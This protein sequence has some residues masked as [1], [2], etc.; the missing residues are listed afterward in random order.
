MLAVSAL[1]NSTVSEWALWIGALVYAHDHGGA[2]AA[3]LVS[4][5]LVVPAACV[6][7]LAGRRADGPRPNRLLGMVYC[8]QALC[9]VTAALAA[10]QDAPL[11]VVTVPIASA[12]TLVTF[13]RPTYSVAIPGLVTAPEQLTAA[14]VL[15]GYF[16]NAAI[17]VG[18]LMAAALLAVGS[19]ALVLAACAAL[20]VV[21]TL[22]SVP[23]A[24][25]DPP[26]AFMLTP[27]VKRRRRYESRGRWSGNWP[28]GPAQSP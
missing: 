10:F 8:V 14:N 24:K 22:C 23:L 9:L 5:A 18:P 6:A 7:P 1:F 28:S 16:E 27:S 21:A 20:L 11:L 25:L 12:T 19:P 17:L 26:T 15:I 2:S 4:V 3:G 13:I